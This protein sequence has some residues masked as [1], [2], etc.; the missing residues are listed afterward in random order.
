MQRE[1]TAFG[2]LHDE[3]GRLMETGWAR[4]PVRVY[5]RRRAAGALRIMEWDHYLIISD[6]YVLALSIGG[7]GLIGMAGVS[8]LDLDGPW[9]KTVSRMRLLPPGSRG[10]GAG[11]K[12]AC[13][14]CG[15]GYALT[16]Q[17]DGRKRRLFG[18][19]LDFREGLPLLFDVTLSGAP[20]ESAVTVTPFPGKPK[21]FSYNQKIICMKAEGKA[22]L[23][24]REYLF[25]PA[26]SHASLDWERGA[27]PRKTTRY[28]ASA[29]GTA[30]GV[31]F[32]FT[33]SCGFGGQAEGGNMLLYAGKAHSLARVDFR[34]P[35]K[36]G[37]EDDGA[38]RCLAGGGRFEMVFDPLPGCAARASMGLPGSGRRRLLGRFTGYAVL[39]D[40]RRIEIRDF[41]GFMEETYIAW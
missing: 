11:A 39:E 22:L 6:R 24:S 7:I 15:S 26:H 18:Q 8:L 41:P 19:I 35:R 3:S 17:N 21:A 9:E 4:R 40:G 20:D 23:G 37:R 14:V 32:G 28:W 30:A 13:A 34:L 2:P 25:A 1:I 10:L 27:W 29:A 5:D 31:P 12:G 36:D 16:F 33:V 38:Q